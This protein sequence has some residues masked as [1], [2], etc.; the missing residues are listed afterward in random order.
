M[1]EMRD[2]LKNKKKKS[3]VLEITYTRIKNEI[4]KI[5][6]EIIFLFCRIFPAIL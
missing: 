5:I 2:D 1:D 3:V 4:M 6:F